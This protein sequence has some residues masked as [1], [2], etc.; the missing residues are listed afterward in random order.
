MNRRD[1]LKGFVAAV[2]TVAIGLRMAKGM[3]L[4]DLK[5]SI[6]TWR[7][8]L[9]TDNYYYGLDTAKPWHVEI[10]KKLCGDDWELI[11]AQDLMAMAE[12]SIQVTEAEVQVGPFPS[13]PEQD[14]RMF[15]CGKDERWPWSNTRYITHET[16][17]EYGVDPNCEEMEAAATIAM[18]QGFAALQVEGGPHIINGD[19]T[20][21]GMMEM[22]VIRVPRIY[23]T[24][25]ALFKH[26]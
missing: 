15:V 12:D 24:Q 8:E 17:E 16:I 13:N 11:Q 22:D 18:S 19:Y 20:A 14:E 2:A 1:L 25:E 9:A 7:W 21:Y 23:D 4:I 5:D 3:P 10:Y 6:A 26:G